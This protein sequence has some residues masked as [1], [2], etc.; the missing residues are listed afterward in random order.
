MNTLNKLFGIYSK[1]KNQSKWIETGF[2]RHNLYDLLWKFKDRSDIY[3]RFSTRAKEFSNPNT[4]YDTPSGLYAYNVKYSINKYFKNF[5]SWLKSKQNSD[6]Y[7]NNYNDTKNREH[8]ESR[9]DHIV[10][11]HDFLRSL[12]FATDPEE[13]KHVIFFTPKNNSDVINPNNYDPSDAINSISNL[14]IYFL[15]LSIQNKKATGWFFENTNYGKIFDL[16]FER[17]DFSNKDLINDLTKKPKNIWYDFYDDI[18]GLLKESLNFI[19]QIQELLEE[20]D[21]DSDHYSFYR[22]I[23]DIE[24][25]YLYLLDI[26]EKCFVEDFDETV[27]NIKDYLSDYIDEILYNAERLINY[28]EEKFLNMKHEL[29]QEFDDNLYNKLTDYLGELYALN[30]VM[31][32]FSKDYGQDNLYNDNDDDGEKFDYDQVYNKYFIKSIMLYEDKDK[33]KKEIKKETKDF[34][35]MLLYDSILNEFIEKHSDVDFSRIWYL[36]SHLARQVDTD[37]KSIAGR[38]RTLLSQVCDIHIVDDRGNGIIHGNEEAQVWIAD[39]TYVNVVDMVENT[40]GMDR[41][42]EDDIIK[43]KVDLGQIIFKKMEEYFKIHK[44]AKFKAEKINYDDAFLYKYGDNKD[45]LEFAIYFSKDYISVSNIKIDLY[46]D[47]DYIYLGNIKLYCKGFVFQEFLNLGKNL[48]ISFKEN[49]K[50]DNKISNHDLF[51]KV[52]EET[53]KVTKVEG[54]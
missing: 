51:S 4:S 53:F 32:D 35:N 37:K 40:F 41:R 7:H 14:F 39:K 27:K 19:Y 13:Y 47:I 36:C 24:E 26:K 46:D 11:I 2:D 18:K 25:I 48:L 31:A 21:L 50:I 1:S 49:K 22:N 23:N 3:F 43:N 44:N 6:M 45:M 9:K 8:E 30:N 54:N 52:I 10:Y 5:D 20:N 42:L 28:T 29:D 38:F 15:E 17:I 34:I 12:P 33:F 16:I